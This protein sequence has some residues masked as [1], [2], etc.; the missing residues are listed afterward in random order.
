MSQRLA[1][2]Y[3]TAMLPSSF[4]IGTILGDE[5]RKRQIPVWKIFTLSM[6]AI[7]IYPLSMPYLAYRVHKGDL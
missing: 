3:T 7:S 1:Q 5:G 2:L 6:L 4:V